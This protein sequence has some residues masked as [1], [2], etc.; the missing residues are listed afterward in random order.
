LT[1]AVAVA[2]VIN[3]V[4]GYK[5]LGE[6]DIICTYEQRF[7]FPYTYIQRVIINELPRGYARTHTH[8]H[9]YM[10]V[11]MYIYITRCCNRTTIKGKRR[12]RRKHVHSTHEHKRVYYVYLVFSSTGKKYRRVILW[13]WDGCGKILPPIATWN[14]ELLLFYDII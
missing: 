13:G 2:Y 8:T 7:N 9:V 14:L 5:N 10:C 4:A 11:Y 3:I 6:F 12:W 1:D